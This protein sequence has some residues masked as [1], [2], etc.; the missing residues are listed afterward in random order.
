MKRKLVMKV[1]VEAYVEEDQSQN[2]VK[3]I[4]RRIPGGT[5]VQADCD[6]FGSRWRAHSNP[7]CPNRR[8]TAT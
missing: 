5:T 1:R 3:V 7:K 6:C 2:G 8:A 4:V